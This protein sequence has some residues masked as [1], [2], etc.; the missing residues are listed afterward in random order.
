[1]PT[2]SHVVLNVV[3]VRVDHRHCSATAT[4]TQILLYNS[5]A[6]TN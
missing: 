3:L 5:I 1:M 2:T 6:V 4:S